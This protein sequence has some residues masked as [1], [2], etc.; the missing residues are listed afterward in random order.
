MIVDEIDLKYIFNMMCEFWLSCYFF[1]IKV[2]VVYLRVFGNVLF[3]N[4]FFFIVLEIFFIVY[5]GYDVVYVFFWYFKFWVIDYILC[6]L[7]VVVF[8][9]Y[10]K[11]YFYYFVVIIN[12]FNVN[13][14]IVS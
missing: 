13:R 14:S 9:N 7:I 11:W 5:D 12:D 8:I 1:V 6:F 2:V 4:G 3:V 10:F